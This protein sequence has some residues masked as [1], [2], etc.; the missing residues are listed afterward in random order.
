MSV[1]HTSTVWKDHLLT[2]TA[3]TRWVDARSCYSLIFQISQD[4]TGTPVGA[5]TVEETNDPIADFETRSTDGDSTAST[6]KP[7]NISADTTRVTILGTGLTV[8]AAN[9]TE[10]VIIN[11]ARFVRLKYTRA[12]GGTG[13]KAQIWASGRES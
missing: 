4:N 11:P 2:A 9:E 12:S 1:Q 3:A 13:A 7:I 5:Y 6:A 10:I 8:S